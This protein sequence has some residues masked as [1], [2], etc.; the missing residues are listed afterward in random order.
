MQFDQR[1]SIDA[2]PPIWKGLGSA[3][4]LEKI[5]GVGS[6]GQVVKA[7]SIKDD[8]AVA[9]K[10]I[11]NAFESV[12]SAKR[13]Y[14]EVAILRHL[15]QM[16]NNDHTTKLLDVIVPERGVFL[17]MS[18][19]EQDLAQIFKEKHQQELFSMD[20]AK[21]ILYNLLCAVNFLHSANV[22]HRDLKP[23]NLLITDLKECRV[24]LCDFGLARTLPKELSA[25]SK[26]ASPNVQEG[27]PKEFARKNRFQREQI[28]GILN[29][30]RNTRKKL[31]R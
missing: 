26:V 20:Q 23:G 11:E 16:S 14:R 1:S 17:V 19:V 12:H 24:F 27:K 5:Q 6:F 3:Y 18:Y 29:S 15:T 7:K 31:Y 4:V 25:L 28:A 22:I 2:L 8:Q 13:V 10:Y 9:I 30:C 21:L